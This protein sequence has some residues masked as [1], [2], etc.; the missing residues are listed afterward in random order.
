M[1][2]PAKKKRKAKER[3]RSDP[4][5]KKR[6][7]RAAMPP[8]PTPI[9][10][11]LAVT[12]YEDLGLKINAQYGQIQEAYGTRTLRLNPDATDPHHPDHKRLREVRRSTSQF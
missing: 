7:D 11:N 12:P 5:K 6:D 3:M 2:E 9:P 1:A 8:P 4:P 10:F